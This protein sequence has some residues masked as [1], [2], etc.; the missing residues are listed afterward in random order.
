M[1]FTVR[2]HRASGIN[3]DD[4]FATEF[5]GMRAL[6]SALD[7]HRKSGNTVTQQHPLFLYIVTD[8]LGSFI[9]RTELVFPG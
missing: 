6:Q 5:E 2:S 3:T 9:Q 7:I 1:M 4:C 8:T